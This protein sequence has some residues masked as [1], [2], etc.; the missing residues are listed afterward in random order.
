MLGMLNYLPWFYRMLKVLHFMFDIY[1]VRMLLLSSQ[2]NDVQNILNDTM[3]EFRAHNSK[4]LVRK[5]KLQGVF[6]QLYKRMNICL[7]QKIFL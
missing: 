1:G 2:N 7:P 6:L 5:K 4:R 3:P